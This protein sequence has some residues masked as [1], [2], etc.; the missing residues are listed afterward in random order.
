MITRFVWVSVI[1]A[2]CG[3]A[4]PAAAQIF[5][6]A[7]VV[8][9]GNGSLPGTGTPTGFGTNAAAVFAPQPGNTYV[10]GI[11]VPL[12]GGTTQVTSSGLTYDFSPFVSTPLTFGGPFNGPTNNDPSTLNGNPNY[13]GDPF[14]HSIMTA[15]SNVG[16]TFDLQAIRLVNP[17]ITV[18]NV[19][20]GGACSVRCETFVLIDGGLVAQAGP[21]GNNNFQALSVP[22]PLTASFLTLVM[23]DGNSGSINCA[24]G[25]LGDPF[26]SNGS[27]PC[28]LSLSQ[29]FPGTLQ[30][31]NIGC[32][33]FNPYV[34]AYTFNPGAFPLGWFFGI[35][36][37]WTVLIAQA[38][39]PLGPPTNGFFDTNGGSLWI[40]PGGVPAGLSIY[41]VTIDIDPVTGQPNPTP[42]ISF[43]TT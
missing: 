24:H 2:V 4:T 28:A 42:A 21:F 13:T 26:L 41:A 33:P 37:S 23:G 20:A 12:S 10:D 15:H 36:I 3:M 30:V 6:L 25:Y 29:P 9:G 43:T 27:P 19:N 18:F 7:D 17:S 31:E 38:T 40:L 16:I 35:D 32:T 11:F 39:S 1:V 34:T 14:N 5:D 8:G 22:V